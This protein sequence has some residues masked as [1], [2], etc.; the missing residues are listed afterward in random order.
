MKN[1]KV[2]VQMGDHIEEIDRQHIKSIHNGIAIA[3]TG[4]SY[5]MVCDCLEVKDYETVS[6]SESNGNGYI[7]CNECNKVHYLSDL[8]DKQ[9]DT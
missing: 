3:T 6:D 1:N 9:I 8:R 7:V 5:T 2:K 4:R